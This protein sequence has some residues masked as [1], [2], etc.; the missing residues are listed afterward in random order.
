[1]VPAPAPEAPRPRIASLIAA[2]A[3]TYALVATLVLLVASSFF[4]DED[5]QRTILVW[6]TVPIVAS[7]W[8]WMAVRSANAYL[9]LLVWFLVL[10]ILFFC[11]LTI[12]SI[13]LY[14]LPA[15]VLLVLA[16]LGPWDDGGE[17]EDA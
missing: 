17:G 16:A 6:L 8:G 7:F 1:L 10:A 13:G 9:R 11:W 14:Y 4:V 15:P 2:L 5:N 12:F 3:F